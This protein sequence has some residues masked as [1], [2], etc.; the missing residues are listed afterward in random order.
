MNRDNDR[1]IKSANQLSEYQ[2]KYL[3]DNQHF[4]SQWIENVNLQ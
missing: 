2:A 4:I 3:F 1:T